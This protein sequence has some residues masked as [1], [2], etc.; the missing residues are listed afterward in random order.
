[1]V[2]N[3]WQLLTSSSWDFN[4]QHIQAAQGESQSQVIW[5]ELPQLNFGDLMT[6]STTLS[7]SSDS[8]ASQTLSHT[9][10]PFIHTHFMSL[11]VAFWNSAFACMQIYPHHYLGPWL[12]LLLY[13]QFIFSHSQSHISLVPVFWIIHP[14]TLASLPLN[15][16]EHAVACSGQVRE[17]RIRERGSCITSVF[18][19]VSS[20]SG[21]GVLE[22]SRWGSCPRRRRWGGE[23][24]NLH[25]VVWRRAQSC[26]QMAQ[27]SWWMQRSVLDSRQDL[28]R[29]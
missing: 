22:E 24:L 19:R 3:Y 20:G 25:W 1:M 15:Y 14:V 7:H 17:L 10:Y 8:M 6:L 29:F 12:Q 11:K 26:T 13:S 4:T 28:Q 27:Q 9:Q 18:H 5:P 16:S 21:G 23:G 2:D